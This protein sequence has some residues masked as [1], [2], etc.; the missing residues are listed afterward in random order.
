MR[1]NVGGSSIIHAVLKEVWN[2]NTLLTA[3][4]LSVGAH[5]SGSSSGPLRSPR[6]P[7]LFTP[8]SRSS[9]LW[10]LSFLLFVARP[11]LGLLR[12]RGKKKQEVSCNFRAGSFA[13]RVMEFFLRRSCQTH[14]SAANGC[15]KLICQRSCRRGQEIAFGRWLGR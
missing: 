2:S 1:A 5:A 15:R 12:D 4:G 3:A 8:W 9:A 10:S 6:T 13:G 14:P 7:V 11:R